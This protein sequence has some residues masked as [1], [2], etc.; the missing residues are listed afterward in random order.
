MLIVLALVFAFV[1]GAVLGGWWAN[2]EIRRAH[3]DP[4]PQRLTGGY[5][6][7]GW[8]WWP[9]PPRYVCRWVDGSGS[10]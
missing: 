6:R 5:P 8:E 7:C 1:A 2:R 4:P 10:W 9:L 3:A